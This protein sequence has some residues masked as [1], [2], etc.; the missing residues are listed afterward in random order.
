M[1]LVGYLYE[2][3]DDTRSLEHKINESAQCSVNPMFH[4]KDLKSCVKVAQT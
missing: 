3:Y 2:D 4:K 1:H